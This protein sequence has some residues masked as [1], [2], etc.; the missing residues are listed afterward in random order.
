MDLDKLIASFQATADEALSKAPLIQVQTYLPS[1]RKQTDGAWLGGRR[2]LAALLLWLEGRQQL[3]PETTARLNSSSFDGSIE[4][5]IQALQS[6]MGDQILKTDVDQPSGEFLRQYCSPGIG[7]YGDDFHALF[8]EGTDLGSFLDVRPSP[9]EL[10]KLFAVID[11]R[12]NAYQRGD[13]DWK[14]SLQASVQALLDRSPEPGK[15]WDMDS[16][17]AAVHSFDNIENSPP[18]KYKQLVAGYLKII[19]QADGRYESAVCAELVRTYSVHLDASVQSGV[20]R[21]LRTFPP[22]MVLEGLIQHLSAI[23][24]SAKWPTELVDVFD[25][26]LSAGI[27]D[28]MADRLDGLP[29]PSRLTYLTFLRQ[30]QRDGSRHASRLLLIL[31]SSN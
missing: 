8:V 4:A 14:S 11:S 31:D 19:D 12:F 1:K 20:W 30:A 17:I 18:G 3:T 6:A 16:W 29:Q 26:D 24:Q 9:A 15:P 23:E 22:L 28:Q 2:F 10:Q 25:D 13:T 21:L 7:S 5:G 27:I